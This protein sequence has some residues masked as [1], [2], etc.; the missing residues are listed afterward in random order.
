MTN[1][2]GLRD[3]RI[4]EV[5]IPQGWAICCNCGDLWLL[6]GPGHICHY[7]WKLVPDERSA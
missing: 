3:G 2:Y 1:R 5:D 4:I 7:G 6:L